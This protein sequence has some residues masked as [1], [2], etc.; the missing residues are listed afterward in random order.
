MSASHSRLLND[1][2]IKG[3]PSVAKHSPAISRGMFAEQRW[4]GSITLFA[5]RRLQVL[6]AVRRSGR[7]TDCNDSE[8]GQHLK[9]RIQ[10][11]EFGDSPLVNQTRENTQNSEAKN[12][13]D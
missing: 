1:S 3:E 4:I 7:F 2:V 10:R 8:A 5:V 9:E 12:Q 11:S 13:K 6:A